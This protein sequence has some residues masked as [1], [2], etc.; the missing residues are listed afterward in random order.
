MCDPITLSLSAAAASAGL[1]AA[2]TAVANN[3]AR[4]NQARQAANARAIAE[5][6][7]RELDESRARMKRL[8]DENR[9]TL[10]R[11]TDQYTPE[12]Q[13]RKRE[14]AAQDATETF[15]NAITP[16]AA[17]YQPTA[18]DTPNIVGATFDKATSAARSRGLSRAMSLGN[19]DSYKGALLGNAIDLQAAGR[20]VDMVNGFARQEA[21]LLPGYQDFAGNAAALP[22]G[23]AKQS[24]GF[25]DLLLG[26]GKMGAS[27]A[28]S[29]SLA[30]G[31]GSLARYFQ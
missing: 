31:V 6:R 21:A 13:N 29:G 23:G 30:R 9:Q 5:A 14:E 16:Q 7:N 27:A 2:G 4:R 1:S 18:S 3:E 25:G 17:A 11:T 10:D 28:G 15:S 26:L 8:D 20:N 12:A 24:S 22:N 19:L